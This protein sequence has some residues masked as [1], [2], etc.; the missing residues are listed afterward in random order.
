MPDRWTKPDVT[1]GGD[2]RESDS[3]HGSDEEALAELAAQEG[4]VHPGERVAE[5]GLSSD[6]RGDDHSTR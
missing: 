6:V 1:P 3:D 4:I 5:V 2:P